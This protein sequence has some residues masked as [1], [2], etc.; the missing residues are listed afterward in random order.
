MLGRRQASGS[1]NPRRLLRVHIRESEL[2]NWRKL[3]RILVW[4]EASTYN[5]IY[6]CVCIHMY[7]YLHI[8][9]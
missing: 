4:S 2:G 7:V 6:V 1:S 8:H 3:G 9:H 5:G